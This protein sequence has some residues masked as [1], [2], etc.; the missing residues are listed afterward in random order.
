MLYFIIGQLN[1]PPYRRLPF[2]YSSKVLDGTPA[3]H[4]IADDQ[5]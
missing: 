5:T 1:F 4:Q 2:K 3:R